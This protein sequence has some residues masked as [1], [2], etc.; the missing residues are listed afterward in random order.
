MLVNLL[1]EISCFNLYF[2]TMFFRDG[3]FD[4][5]SMILIIFWQRNY[6][7]ATLCQLS[8][9]LFHVSENTD[10]GEKIQEFLQ[11]FTQKKSEIIHSTRVQGWRSGE[12]TRLPPILSRFD[13]S[14]RRHM[15]AQFVGSL[16]CTERFS[17]YSG[18]P[19]PQKTNI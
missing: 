17:L 9:R 3:N 19:S 13:S 5:G 2:Y 1:E 10:L 4:R 8:D 18:F 11:V 6:D 12:S 14:T 15:W 7:K 16:L